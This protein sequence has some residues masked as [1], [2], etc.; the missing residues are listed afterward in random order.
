M[1]SS[2]PPSRRKI[3]VAIDLSEESERVLD[4]ALDE[5]ASNALSAEVHV[6]YVR[7]PIVDPAT[8]YGV[9]AA[10]SPADDLP[11]V[12]KIVRDRVDAA[13]RRSGALKVA[14][15]TAHTVLGAPAREIAHV[16]AELDVD[17][18]I[19]GTH[20]RRGLR[21]A[22]LGSVAEHVVR[23][24]GCPVLTI[25][26]KHHTED[27]VVPQ[28][29]PLCEDCAEARTRSKGAE[30]WCDRHREHHPRAHVFSYEER[31]TDSVRPWGF[32][33]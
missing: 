14:S 15:V 1:T 10:L 22:L 5:A 7:E 18:V 31:S 23:Y 12:Q 28:V 19:V 16:A 33:Q 24:A 20:G 2:P 29:E 25:R 8:A 30:L 4:A 27:E 13:I 26:S 21:R 3:L 11:L 9:A 17:L 32:H 6:L